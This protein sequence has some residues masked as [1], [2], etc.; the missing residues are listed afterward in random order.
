MF[1]VTSYSTNGWGSQS[2][3]YVFSVLTEGYTTP[4]I[5]PGTWENP[6]RGT[7][8]QKFS[9]IETGAHTFRLEAKV[10]KN[11][12]GREFKNDFY[13][14]TI[15]FDDTKFKYGSNAKIKLKNFNIFEALV[16]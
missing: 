5:I 11:H 6:R 9:T 15:A 14:G 2:P 3:F 4:L 10:I 16:D 13:A 7:F 1:T 12:D 8:V